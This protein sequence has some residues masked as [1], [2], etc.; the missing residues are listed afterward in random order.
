MTFIC[1]CV[2]K[3]RRELQQ[4]ELRV[5]SLQEANRVC[6]QEQLNEF[7]QTDARLSTL[8]L[9]MESLIRLTRLYMVKLGPR[10]GYDTSELYAALDMHNTTSMNASQQVRFALSF[11]TVDFKKAFWPKG[12]QQNSR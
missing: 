12:Y 6:T 4:Y 2:Q 9:R 7:K 8:W 3:L 10:L 11:Y 5:A 1:S